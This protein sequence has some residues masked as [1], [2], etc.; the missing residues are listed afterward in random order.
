MRVFCAMVL[1]ACADCDSATPASMDG[2]AP[3]GETPVVDS[4]PGLDALD[5]PAS[6]AGA[7]DVT[8]SMDAP[9]P[10]SP[11][12]EGSM[13]APPADS[14]TTDGSVAPPDAG[15]FACADGGSCDVATEF[16][17]LVEGGADTGAGPVGQ[18]LPLPGAC[19]S[20]P[21]CACLIKN[22]GPMTYPVSLATC[23][24][25]SGQILSTIGLP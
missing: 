13:D 10:D 18:C 24:D 19:L 21:S 25:T 7:G 3:E 23:T 11:T 8:V 2:S 17:Q 4:A 14:S 6:D 12:T 22:Q 16:C 15:A 20:A 1:F 9:P 5:A